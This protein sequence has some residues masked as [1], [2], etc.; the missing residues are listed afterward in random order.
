MINHLKSGGEQ[1][2]DIT[3]KDKKDLNEEYQDQNS[4]KESS[5]DA[6]KEE[7]KIKKDKKDKKEN[8]KNI[9]LDIFF[10]SI[11]ILYPNKKGK[12]GVKPPQRKKL[13]QL[14][15]EKTKRCIDRYIKAK[16]EWQAWQHG[17][18]FFN[19]GYTD[20]IAD[21]YEEF[22]QPKEQPKGKETNDYLDKIINQEA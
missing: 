2:V 20:Y 13:E 3:K 10:E 4:D 7:K 17:S 11:W 15:F 1:K 16:P 19:S 22:A 12:Y 14:G 5:D 18:T 21:D 6:V 8:N 9:E